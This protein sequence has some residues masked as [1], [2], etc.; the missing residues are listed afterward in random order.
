IAA[1]ATLQRHMAGIMNYVTFPI[2]NASSEGM[3][4]IIQSLR[5]AARGLPNFANFRARILFH[6]GD[7]DMNPA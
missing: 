3:N 1:A 5:S 6:L 7:L 4:S 2:T